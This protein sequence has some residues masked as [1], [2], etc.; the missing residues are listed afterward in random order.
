MKCWIFIFCIVVSIPAVFAQGL[1]ADVLIT[2]DETGYAEV[3]GMTNSQKIIS[4]ST[5]T[6]KKSDIWTFSASELF[7]EYVVE[8][9]LPQDSII[10]YVKSNA[11]VQI[12][13]I[14]DRTFVR[15][16]ESNS[17]FN[18]TIQYSVQKNESPATAPWYIEFIG[19]V[20]VLG[21]FS[22]IAYLGR[23]RATKILSANVKTGID[24]SMLSERQKRIVEVL[25]R[26][27]VPL[28]QMQICTELDL[29]KS[30]VSRNIDAL[31]KKDILEKSGVGISNKVRIKS[32][33]QV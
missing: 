29:P 33:R 23:K 4:S 9:R 5:L 16:S 17:L 27:K 26:A 6:S 32:T 28:T 25:E 13:T 14:A 12:G 24:T 3:Q 22:A 7:E 20:I 30:S 19:I 11:P 1:Y 18:V 15:T 8:I 31:V 10:H 2:L 21:I